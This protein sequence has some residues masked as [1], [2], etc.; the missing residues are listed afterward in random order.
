MKKTRLAAIDIGTNSI[1][2]IV[3]EVDP[4]GKFTVLDDEKATVRL[5]ENLS[6]S[7]LISPVA[8]GRAV[9]AVGRIQKLIEGFNVDEVVAVATSAIRNALNGRALVDDLSQGLGREINVI[10][11]QEEAELAAISALYN[12]D[13]SGK[14]YAM[15]DIGGGS[16]EI[17]FAL[18]NHIEEYFSLDLG[19][20]LMTEQFFTSDPIRM[21]D[22]DDFR[23]HVRNELKK[24]FTGERVVVQSFIGSGG[25][26]TSLGGMVMNM[27][28]Q[29]FTSVHGYEVLR[30]EV[31]HLLAMLMRKDV[32]A[33]RVVPGLNPERADI[34]VAGL[35]VV[36]ELMKF[37]GANLLQVNERGIREG[38]ILKAIKRMGIM[39][40]GS[41][42]TWRTSVLEFARSCHYDES[43]SRHV[44]NLALAIF[45]RVAEESVLK[46]SERRMLE[47]AALLHDIGYFISYNSHH[48]HSYHLIRHADLFGFTPREREIIAQIARYHRKALPK[49]KHAEF[50]Q[51]N[52]K[53]RLLVNRLGGILRLADGL[54]RRRSGLVEVVDLNRSGDVYT[55]KL[56]GTEDISVEIFGGNAKRDLFEKSFVCQV[57]LITG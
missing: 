6:K 56:L 20:V 17:V 41:Q 51:L 34:I 5:G 46:K 18:G 44:A 3:V 36:D 28:Q 40:N 35:G 31:V 7:G 43:H 14:R 10:S 52:D 33:R 50:S 54:D 12:F 4:Q 11:G 27:R 48:K 2:C 25:T 13:M 39:Q 16:V 26:I 55:F 32:K 38:L 45:E 29:D 53:D 49:K 9:D 15:I 57:K 37:F 47:A 42:R 30:S 21:S 24:V 19:A 1:R 23:R 8:C 22:Y